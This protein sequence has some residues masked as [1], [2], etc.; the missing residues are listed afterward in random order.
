M[1][2]LK[3]AGKIAHIRLTSHL[4]Q[5]GYTLC[6]YTPALWKHDTRSISFTLVVENFGVKYV[7]KQQEQNPIDALRILYKIT[8]DWVGRKYLCIAFSWNYEQGWVDIPMPNYVLKVMHE[9][10]HPPPPCP[11]YAQSKY[12]AQIYGAKIQ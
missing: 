9:F 7:G 12:K 4:K 3:Q 6:R 5:S 10:Q 1:P 8:V 2:V 11:V